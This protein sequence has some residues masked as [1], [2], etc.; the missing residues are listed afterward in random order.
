VPEVSYSVAL[1]L[2][3]ITDAIVQGPEVGGRAFFRNAG[4][5]HNDGAEIG[6][7]VAPV[8]GLTLNGAYT[9]ARYRFVEYQLGDTLS[10]EG[11]RLPG[12]PEHFW[13]LGLRTSLPADFY[14][15]ADHTISSSILADDA[16]TIWAPAWGAGVTNLRFGWSGQAGLMEIAPFLGVNNL[17]DRRYVGAVTLN[18]IGG[19]V[20]EPAPRRVIYVGAELG[21][22]AAP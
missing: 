8:P 18:G 10:L 14:L 12:V 6:V 19:R 3:R 15:D 2:G 21:Y 7:S 5:T 13:R 1:F 9:Y 16:N 20:F 22:A 11:K 4:K 17:W